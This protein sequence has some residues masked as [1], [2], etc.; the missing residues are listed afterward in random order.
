MIHATA[1]GLFTIAPGRVRPFLFMY[2]E[3]AFIC[4]ISM[5]MQCLPEKDVSEGAKKIQIR[6]GGDGI[7]IWTMRR[8]STHSIIEAMRGSYFGTC[9]QVVGPISITPPRRY[10]DDC[11]TGRPDN[12]KEPG[13]QI[14]VWLVRDHACMRAHSAV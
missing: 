3:A 4:H 11:S 5:Y 7:S 6:T 12:L 13:G 14:A 1:L 8:F 10:H 9:T 2:S